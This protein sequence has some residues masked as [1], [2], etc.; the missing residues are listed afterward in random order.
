[1]EVYHK[2]MIILIKI[3]NKKE[4]GMTTEQQNQKISGV[5]EKSQNKC[6]LPVFRKSESRDF[7]QH[8]SSSWCPWIPAL[9]FETVSFQPTASRL[10]LLNNSSQRGPLSFSIA[11]TLFCVKPIGDLTAEQHRAGD[12]GWHTKYLVGTSVWPRLVESLFMVILLGR[13]WQ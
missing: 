3:T 13:T 12:Y 8:L 11:Y 10:P 9:C 6:L 1:M 4:C 7:S 2:M 5:F